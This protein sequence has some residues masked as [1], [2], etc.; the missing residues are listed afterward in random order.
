MQQ[1]L[2]IHP[3]GRFP[4]DLALRKVGTLTPNDGVEDSDDD[5]DAHVIGAAGAVPGSSQYD[6]AGTTTT[7]PPERYGGQD[8]YRLDNVRTEAGTVHEAPYASQPYT[9]PIR[10]P[11]D[12]GPGQLQP[13][14][15]RQQEYPTRTPDQSI[16]AAQPVQPQQVPA[17]QNVVPSIEPPQQQQQQQSFLG[18][19]PANVPPQASLARHT[20][21]DYGEW[22]A[23]AAVGAAGL[24]AGGVGAA[25]HR[26]RQLQQ[27]TPAATNSPQHDVIP[28]PAVAVEPTNV[29][30]HHLLGDLQT[31]TANRVS[32]SSSVR[33]RSSASPALTVRASAIHGSSIDTRALGEDAL[34]AAAIPAP[35]PAPNPKLPSSSASPNHPRAPP[36]SPPLAGNE[37][38]GARATGHFFPSVVRHNTGLSISRLHVPG[39]FPPSPG[40]STF[41]ASPSSLNGS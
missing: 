12:A 27:N 7:A 33:T 20:T 10:E 31:T 4:S 2:L 8:P 40:D 16:G 26:H 22:M 39:E 17:Q 37:R 23:P 11:S 28:P 38:E 30:D 36:A 21:E 15:V 1:Q 5:A 18:R 13:L 14:P 9:E 6:Y 32:P 24:G 34:A 29:E 19:E 25:A 35:H 3:G 41:T